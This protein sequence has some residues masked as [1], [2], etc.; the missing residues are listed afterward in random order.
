[1]SGVSPLVV[2]LNVSL[3]KSDF[4]SHVMIDM[5]AQKTAESIENVV[6]AFYAVT[7]SRSQHFLLCLELCRLLQGNFLD[8]AQVCLLS[9]ISSSVCAGSMPAHVLRMYRRS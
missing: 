3:F 9:W 2:L 1:M 8:G 4:L 6:H 5:D 7:F